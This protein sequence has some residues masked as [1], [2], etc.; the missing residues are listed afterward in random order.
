MDRYLCPPTE[1][2]LYSHIL[3]ELLSILLDL[4]NQGDQLSHGTVASRRSV[5]ESEWVEDVCQGSS[6]RL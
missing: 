6:N 5:D 4:E 3:L 1:K 2:P